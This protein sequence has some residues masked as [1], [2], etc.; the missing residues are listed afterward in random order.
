MGIHTLH[1]GIWAYEYNNPDWKWNSDNLVLIKRRYLLHYLNIHAGSTWYS[2][3]ATIVREPDFQ[4]DIIVSNM[5]K[6]KKKK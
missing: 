2:E 1:M 3:Q 4:R 6:E 5:Q